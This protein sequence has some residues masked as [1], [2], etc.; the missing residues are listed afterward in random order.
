MGGSFHS[1]G[2]IPIRLTVG[3]GGFYGESVEWRSLNGGTSWR[4]NTQNLSMEFPLGFRLTGVD[5]LNSSG[6][7]NTNLE[8]HDSLT[9]L[10]GTRCEEDEGSTA[11]G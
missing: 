11:T 7:R 9:G 3:S 2:C 4:A 5:P 8:S 1:C 10:G 6:H